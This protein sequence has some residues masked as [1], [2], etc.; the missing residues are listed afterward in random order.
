MGTK[1]Q[2]VDETISSDDD[3]KTRNVGKNGKKAK[4]IVILSLP[5]LAELLSCDNYTHSVVF[6]FFCK[7]RSCYSFF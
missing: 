4:L 5:A 6:L 1:K 7:S 3:E 2:S